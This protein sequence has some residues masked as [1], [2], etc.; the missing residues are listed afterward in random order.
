MQEHV[1]WTQVQVRIVAHG[2]NKSTWEETPAHEGQPQKTPVVPAA[3]DHTHHVRQ[4]RLFAIPAYTH[5]ST[6]VFTKL[7]VLLVVETKLRLFDKHKERV[8][9]S[10]HGMMVDTSLSIFL[11]YFSTQ[12]RRLP[13]NTVVSL[14]ARSPIALVRLSAPATEDLCGVT[15]IFAPIAT[16]TGTND[17]DMRSRSVQ[18]SPF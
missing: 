7:R 6:Y 18:H 13:K 15:H 4:R 9:N 10:V 16:G 3:D 11:G 17:R 12:E 8:L 1:P 5:M 14:P 2:T